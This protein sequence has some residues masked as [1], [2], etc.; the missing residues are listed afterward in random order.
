MKGCRL[1]WRFDFL[2]KDFFIQNLFLLVRC[3]KSCYIYTHKYH[4]RTFT[5]INIFR[6]A[7]VWRN[8]SLPVRYRIFFIVV[9]NLD[10]A[11][12]FGQFSTVEAADK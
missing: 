9:E 3:L 1:S 5:I 11:N 7:D 8:T 4:T 10:V 2:F 12:L 6:I